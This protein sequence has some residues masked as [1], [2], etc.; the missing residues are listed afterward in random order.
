MLFFFFFF[1]ASSQEKST[2]IYACVCT[3]FTQDQCTDQCTCLSLLLCTC[4][5]N[6]V[7]SRMKK[8]TLLCPLLS[9]N[10][11][12][13]IDTIPPLINELWGVGDREWERERRI[14]KYNMLIITIPVSFLD[15]I[16]GSM[17]TKP[18]SQSPEENLSG[19]IQ[20]E[21]TLNH[22]DSRS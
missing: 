13:I 22:S 1:V 8:R 5:Y 6:S 12:L 2:P 15:Q 18:S 21:N 7:T 3:T 9:I 14:N 16:N 4:I 20:I 10:H 19:F 11:L 17:L